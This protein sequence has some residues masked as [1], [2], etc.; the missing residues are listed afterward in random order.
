MAKSKIFVALDVGSSKISTIFGDLDEIGNLY[1][2]GSGESLSKG[3]EKGTVISP[4]D[5]IKSIKE[6]ITTGEN[7]SGFK[8][9]AVL[10]NIGGQ[11][12]EAK[13][14]KESIAFS[15][16]NKE[17]EKNDVNSLIEKINSKYQSDSTTILHII[18]TKY[19]LDDEDIV[20]DPIGL[21]GSKLTGEFTV[22]TIKTSTYNNI[23][24]II[25]STGLRIIDT[26]VN[27]LAS[28][29]SVLYPEEKELGVALIDIGGSLSD[30]AIYK[31]GSLEMLKSIPLGGSLIT[32]DIAFRFKI[33][34]E[35]AESVKIHY[36]MA[37][38]EF[39]EINDYIEV[40]FR[41]NEES[42]KIER[43]DLVE[44]IEWRLTEIFELLRKELEKSGL[45]DKLTSGIVLTGGV[46]NT[47]YIQDLAERVF[48][49]DVR[50]G[51]PKEFKCFS[52]KLYSPQYSTAIGMLQFM[53]NTLEKTEIQYNNNDKN[54]LNIE[55][56]INKIFNK[57]K[58][59]F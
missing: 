38:T 5:A 6:S 31:N 57:F 11:H 42:I 1:V 33:S 34:K 25:E 22:I 40:P 27:S 13:K 54:L 7:A 21:I 59:M 17:I 20:Y 45:Y 23:K 56:V 43:K 50:I 2:I 30:I 44:T 8:V 28:A 48:E 52:E 35:L 39:L 9:S 46:A 24:K 36:G 4:S 55:G 10:V 12:I 47:P 37:S 15:M 18:P 14:E 51:K 32:K 3:I 41:E 58:E 26:I 29:T 16:P 53:S 19:I 49:K